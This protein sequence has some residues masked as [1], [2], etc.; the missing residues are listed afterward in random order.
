M[1]KFAKKQGYF[2]ESKV[3][4]LFVIFRNFMGIIL[5]KE[6]YGMPPV[7]EGLRSCYFGMDRKSKN[8]NYLL[9][10]SVKEFA[11]QTT[12]MTGIGAKKGFLTQSKDLK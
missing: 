3:M 10:K 4:E 8:P 12:K 1:G 11:K 5:E 6:V 7:D 2:E 9:E